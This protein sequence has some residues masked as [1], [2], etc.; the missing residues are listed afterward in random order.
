MH[1]ADLFAPM[2]HFFSEAEGAFPWEL[3]H[4]EGRDAGVYWEQPG[5]E[6]LGGVHW[7]E[8]QYDPAM[9][10]CSPGG[11]PYPGLHQKHHGQQ[12]GEGILS[13]CFG[14][15]LPRVLCPALEPSGQERHGPVEAGPEEGHKNDQRDGTPLLWGKAERVGVVQSGEENSLGRPYSSLPVPE[16]AYKRAGEGLSTR[17][18]SDRRKGNGFKLKEGRFRLDRRKKFFPVRVVRHW[19]RFPREAVDASPWKC[20]RPGWMGLWATWP[21]GRCPCPCQGGWN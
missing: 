2:H 3:C 10:A 5:G 18:C 11:Q 6:G 17:A 20:T 13:L 4:S 12:V 14:E 15:T 21:C 19:N 7:W 9:C 8:A 16:G 1:R